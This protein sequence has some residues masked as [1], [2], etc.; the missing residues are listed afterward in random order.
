MVLVISDRSVS[1]M[2]GETV[3]PGVT[4]TV[5]DSIG[6][7]VTI[8]VFVIAIVPVLITVLITVSVSVILLL[9]VIVNCS[10]S[11]TVAVN[12]VPVVARVTVRS[13]AAVSDIVLV[14]SISMA[15]GVATG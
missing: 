3:I 14:S 9:I 2:V 5:G 12:S 11:G 4:V 6:V 1:V 7:S 10:L 8:T 13:A 15:V